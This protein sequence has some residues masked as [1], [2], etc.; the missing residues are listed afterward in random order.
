MKTWK[1][2]FEQHAPAAKE[3]LKDRK[4]TKSWRLAK[5]IGISSPLAGHLLRML[6]DWELWTI[7]RNRR[8]RLWYNVKKVSID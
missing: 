1:N 2:L 3:Y 8:R 7:G 4:F 6:D 5:A